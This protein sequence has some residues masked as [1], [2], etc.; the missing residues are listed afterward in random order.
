LGLFPNPTSAYFNLL[1]P[2][3]TQGSYQVFSYNGQLMTEGNVLKKELR[4][5]VSN[6]SGGSYFVLVQHQGGTITRTFQVQH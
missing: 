5:D 1:F 6:W 4:V 3:N 2:E